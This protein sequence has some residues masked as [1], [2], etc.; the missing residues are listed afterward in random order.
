MKA[1]AGKAA[2]PPTPPARIEVLRLGHRPARD[3]RI[4][5]HVCLTAR[6]LGAAR[7]RIAEEDAEVV[8][9][10]AAVAKRFGGGFEVACGTGWK[11]PVRQWQD[12]G[13]QVVHLTM[14]G[15]PLGE[16]VPAIQALRKPVLV[17]VG[18]EKVPAELYQMADHNVAVGSQPHSE[19]AALALML[20]R[21]REGAW[22]SDAYPGGEIRI[23]PSAR[24]KR[25]TALS[26]EADK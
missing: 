7:V 19:V 13:G 21:L 2:A 5:T 14:Y 12:A 9:S 6:A 10:V 4:T 11:A 1:A 23:E 24:G 22:E 16:A 18:A 8:R 3:K 20:D 26:A 17:V 25:V 15:T